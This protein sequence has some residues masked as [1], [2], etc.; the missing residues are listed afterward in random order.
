MIIYANTQYLWSQNIS[1]HSVWVTISTLYYLGITKSNE[2]FFYNFFLN[3]KWY[4]LV[5]CSVHL[6][7]YCVR[8]WQGRCCAHSCWRTTPRRGRPPP[9]T[10]FDPPDSRRHS[11]NSRIAYYFLP[12]LHVAVGG[13]DVYDGMPS[14]VVSIIYLCVFA[15]IFVLC[16]RV[17]LFVCA[18]ACFLR[19]NRLSSTRNAVHSVKAHARA[20]ILLLYAS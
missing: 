13:R 20:Y 18:C 4:Q 1:F 14:V 9:T 16:V 3:K 2:Y 10:P 11:N 12:T 19:A 17:Y 8:P 7:S 15:C 5:S 6:A